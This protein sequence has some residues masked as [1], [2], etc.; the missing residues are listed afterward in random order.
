MPITCGLVSSHAPGLFA[1]TYGGWERLNERFN[2]KTP[3]PPETALEGP[4]VIADYVTRIGS[5]FTALRQHLASAAPDALVVIAGDQNEW[6]HASNMPNLMIYA[7][8]DDV[9]GFHNFGAIDHDPPLVPWKDP[10]RFAVR[11]K[12]DF[13]LAEQ[14]LRGLLRE[15]FD[16]AVSRRQAPQGDSLRGAPHAIARPLPLILPRT[17]LPIVPVMMKTVERSSAMMKGERCLALGRAI[18]AICR[19]LGKRIA[20]YGSGGMSHDPSGPRS[21]WVDEPLDRWFMDQLAAGTP[22]RLRPIYSFQSS[23][24]T[25]GTG[26]LRTWLPVAGAMDSIEPGW[27]ATIVD[28]FPARKTTAGCGWAYWEKTS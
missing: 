13:E 17:D 16:V 2:A 10:E 8:T 9:V 25:S 18:E 22:D 6:F 20:L 19:P 12:V 4:A 15:G 7:G 11:F 24:T 26:E 1:Q 5:A 27:R 21:G 23:A 28:Y 3:Q 14:L